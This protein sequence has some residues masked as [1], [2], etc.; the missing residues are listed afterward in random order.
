MCS[1]SSA[2]LDACDL[3]AKPAPLEKEVDSGT[4]CCTANLDWLTAIFAGCCAGV[5]ISAGASCTGLFSGYTVVRRRKCESASCYRKSTKANQ[6][7]KENETNRGNRKAKKQAPALKLA[8]Q[9]LH[10]YRYIF[11]GYGVGEIN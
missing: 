8:A 4:P 11:V 3:L 7:K 5:P 9:E 2:A 10:T 6:R 1:A